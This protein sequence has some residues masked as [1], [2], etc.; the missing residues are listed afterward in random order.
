MSTTNTFSLLQDM[1]DDV[2][3][4]NKEGHEATTAATATKD[5]GKDHYSEGFAW[6]ARPLEFRMEVAHCPGG[7]ILCV[8]E[9]MQY[10]QEASSL[11]TSTLAAQIALLILKDES[12]SIQAARARESI[13]ASL[14]GTLPAYAVEDVDVE[15][16]L[17]EAPVTYLRTNYASLLSTEMKDGTECSIPVVGGFDSS[18]KLCL[19]FKIRYDV[20]EAAKEAKAVKN[21][22]V[23]AHEQQDAATKGRKL[24]VFGR[25]AFGISTS[26]LAL[27]SQIH[28]GMV[29][30]NA[31]TGG[32]PELW[33]DGAIARIEAGKDK[34]TQERCFFVITSTKAQAEMLLAATDRNLTPPS[35]LITFDG[36]P[37]QTHICRPRT[38]RGGANR[39]KEPHHPATTTR[40]RVQTDQRA[41]RATT[42]TPATPSLQHQAAGHGPTPALPRSCQSNPWAP[43]VAQAKAVQHGALSGGKGKAAAATDYITSVSPDSS[44]TQ[45]DSAAAQADELTADLLS[46]IEALENENKEL[47]RHNKEL[48]ALHKKDQKKGEEGNNSVRGQHTLSEADVQTITTTVQTMVT[49]SLNSNSMLKA[50]ASLK[51]RMEQVEDR[52]Y[53][54][55]ELA[56]QATLAARA[57]VQMDTAAATEESSAS[58]GSDSADRKRKHRSPSP[59][60]RRGDDKQGGGAA[61]MQEEKE[62]VTDAMESDDSTVNQALMAGT[63]LAPSAPPP[64]VHTQTSPLL[65]AAGSGG[66]ANH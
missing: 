27:Q 60:G 8:L 35:L 52:Y 18:L 10:Y 26:P 9:D 4:A 61:L 17:K 46:R 62:G 31:K 5:M 50:I 7:R 19:K 21:E 13:C 55:Q 51:S 16:R 24:K 28:H 47:Q 38:E 40:R 43:R 15:F 42:P 57:A 3:G 34:K 56:R 22:R 11:S 25:D 63:T 32:K 37:L 58:N 44:A 48:R 49:E 65:T 54:Q 39:A 64:G 2:D 20:E 36:K 12:R 45:A 41:L 1:D 23:K 29:N 6:P 66:G 14:Q 53:Q 33:Q 30:F 59:P